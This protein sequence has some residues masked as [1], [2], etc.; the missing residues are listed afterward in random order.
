MRGDL[1]AVY[2]RSVC[3][4]QCGQHGGGGAG[5]YGPGHTSTAARWPISRLDKFAAKFW[6]VLYRKGPNLRKVCFLSLFRQ[7]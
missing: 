5:R 7:R 3:A 6:L 1:Y 2:R 4:L